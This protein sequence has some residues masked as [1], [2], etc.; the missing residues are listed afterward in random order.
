[1]HELSIA[2]AIVRIADSHA[3][4]RKVTR[5]DVRVGHLR[6]V[7][8]SALGFAFE[9]VAAG[10]AVEGAELVVSDIRARVVCRGCGAES[11]VDGFPLACTGCGGVDVE[12]IQGEELYVES[13]E[14]EKMAVA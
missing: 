14:V 5:V 9:M 11:E 3:D 8:P 4:G 1:M 13:I 12:V 6:Q 2:D 7:V 10:T